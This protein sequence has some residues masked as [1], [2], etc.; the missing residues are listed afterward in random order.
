MVNYPAPYLECLEGSKSISRGFS[1]LEEE[2]GGLKGRRAA[3]VRL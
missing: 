1:S 2:G 3:G